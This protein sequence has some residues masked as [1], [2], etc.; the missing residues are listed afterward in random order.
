MKPMKFAHLADA[1][2]GGWRDPK[3]RYL[4]LDA[5]IKAVDRCIDESVDFILVSGD[6]FNTSLPTIDKLKQVVIALKRLKKKD[7]PVYIVAGSHDFSPSGKTMLDVLEEAELFKNV[8][9][10]YVEENRLHLKF[11]V[12]EK[13]GA[14]ITGMIGKKGML[15]RR[16]Y[17]S[18]STQELEKEPGFKI[19]MFHTAISELK[20]KELEK[21]DSAPLSLLP[22]GFDYYAGGHV[23]IVKQADFDSHKN[24]V[25][26]GPLFPNNFTE[27]EKLGR[28]GF[29]IYDDGELR[30]EPIQVCNVHKLELDCSHMNPEQV[31]AALFE[32]IKN[33]EFI[34]TVVLIRLSGVL[35]TGRP[36]DINMKDLFR[37][38]Y[39]KSAHFVMKNTNKL[40]SKEFEEIKI[41]AKSTDELESSLV[42]EHLGQMGVEED[43]VKR[44]IAAFDIEKQDG[45]KNHDFEERLIQEIDKVFE[46][47]KMQ[48]HKPQVRL[49][50]SDSF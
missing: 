17:E 12:D 8:C 42:Q 4:N 30:F 25:Y 3:M 16:F 36:S 35:E 40:I 34:N 47:E 33:K 21:M 39:D 27:L 26:P 18:L 23:H 20:P 9:K 11:T 13:T 14:K 48:S 41:D 2:I 29:Y 49:D 31:S 37:A 45:E 43:V 7:I 38:L 46:N 28:G 32:K 22:K 44:L 6:L 1:H 15:E 10:G 50:R 5:F 24:V 19:F